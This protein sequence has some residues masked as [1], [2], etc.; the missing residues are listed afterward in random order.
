[1]NPYLDTASYATTI[2]IDIVTR[3]I[4]AFRQVNSEMSIEHSECHLQNLFLSIYS[5][6][7]S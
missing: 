6:F 4:G 3:K 2:F 7:N 5:T 1:M